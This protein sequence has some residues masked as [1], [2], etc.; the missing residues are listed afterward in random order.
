MAGRHATWRPPRP[1]T[2]A[3]LSLPARRRGLCRSATFHSGSTTGS[4]LTGVP[5]AH[6]GPGH[7]RDDLVADGPQDPRPVGGCRFTAAARTEQH[8]LGAHRDVVVA[9]VRQYLVHTHPP[10]HRPAPTLD[11][12]LEAVGQAAPALDTRWKESGAVDNATYAR[13]CG[14]ICGM[15]CLRMALLRRDGHAP[16]LF[17]LVEGARK[18]GAYTESTDTGEIRG[19]IY[20]PFAEYARAEHGLTA[21]VHGHLQAEELV[22]LLDTGRI[23]MASVNKEIRRP[24]RP[25]PGQGGHLV[26]VTG[27][28]RGTLRFRNPSGHTA[29][30]RNAAL[31]VALFS[32][33]YGRRGISLT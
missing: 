15:A 16:S 1:R 13:W 22:A 9:A 8:Y 5:P 17:D 21:E 24:D 25:A 18:Y 11:E 7:T 23:V 12:D 2:D 28:E 4:P 6:A 31:P 32:T 20:A 27:H 10:P 33:F 29:E 14:H 19:L 26:L 3:R 30:A